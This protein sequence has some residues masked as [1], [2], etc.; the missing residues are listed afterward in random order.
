MAPT[1]FPAPDLHFDASDLGLT[2][3]EWP[4][5]IHLDGVSAKRFAFVYG[6]EEGD[7]LDYVLYVSDADVP[8]YVYND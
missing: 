2:P 4:L 3:G 6:T 7:T 8:V 1:G 5:A